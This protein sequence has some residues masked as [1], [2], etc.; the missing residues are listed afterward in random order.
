MRTAVFTHPICIEHDPGLGH[1][2]S[3]ERLKSVMNA[4]STEDFNAL[5]RREAPLADVATIKAVHQAGAVD[6]VME[7]IPKSGQ[8]F[9]DPDTALSPHSGE[10]ALRAVGGC[11]AAVD[12]VMGEEVKNAFCAVR[13]PG[14]HAESARSMGF[15]IFNNVAVA[16]DYARKKHGLSRIAVVD[17]D[18]HHGNGTQ[19][20][21]EKDQ[22]LFYAS[23]HQFPYY[24]G[25]GNSSEIGVGN[26]ANLPMAAGDGSDAFRKGYTRQLL[27][28]LR[29]F[30]PE[31]LIISAGF[32]AHE[33]DPLAQIGLREED[34]A[35]V[36]R[37]L[38]DIAE[39]CCHGR[40]VSSLEG[41]YNLRSLASSA[42]AHVRVLLER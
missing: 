20:L 22:D 28:A 30:N 10:A 23:S 35:W 3:P 4:L 40:L 18:V 7:N 31:L 38:R 33:H 25:T 17:F 26:I 29:E 37:E 24:P 27:P 36:T 12:A 8:K 1:P 34:F 2:E 14:H 39:D 42:A 5:E 13:P 15:C 41:G 21:F 19:H 11:I 9:L 16:A 6:L 32:D